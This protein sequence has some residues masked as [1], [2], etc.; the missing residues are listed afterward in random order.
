MNATDLTSAL[1]RRQRRAD[2]SRA[3]SRAD[4]EWL[5]TRKDIAI[6]ERVLWRMLY[7]TAAGRL[8][9]SAWTSRISTCPADGLG[10]GA[11]AVPSM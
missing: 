1:R 2:R 5:L 10:S 3:L 9:C 6:H 8:R 4:V 7:E 11:R